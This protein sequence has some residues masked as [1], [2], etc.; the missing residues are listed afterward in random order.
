M[1][2]TGTPCGMAAGTQRATPDR[3]GRFVLAATVLVAIVVFLWLVATL[4]AA[5]FR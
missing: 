3:S 1:W 2:N 5:A 4:S